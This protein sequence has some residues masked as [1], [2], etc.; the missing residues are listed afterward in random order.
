MRPL[1]PVL[2]LAKP[3]AL[4]SVFYVTLVSVLL[5]LWL[6]VNIKITYCYENTMYG[7]GDL[8]T[9]CQKYQFFVITSLVGI[10][11]KV[12]LRITSGDK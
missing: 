4:G 3:V 9:T 2:L 1:G 8:S 10:C 5:I 11:L 7:D 12:S 6:G